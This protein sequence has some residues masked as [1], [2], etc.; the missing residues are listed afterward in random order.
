MSMDIPLLSKMGKELLSINRVTRRLG[1][2]HPNIGKSN[3]NSC[4]VKNCQNIYTK[5]Q[6]ESPKH[7]HQTTF[8]PLKKPRTNHAFKLLL[9]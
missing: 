1:E 3:P 9:S 8:E 7:L 5:A 6:F 2:N 4:Q